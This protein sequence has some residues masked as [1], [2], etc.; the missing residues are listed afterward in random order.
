M[1]HSLLKHGSKI[2]PSFDDTDESC[3]NPIRI[4][5]P[6]CGKTID[7][8]FLANHKSISEIVGID[9]IRKAL[10]DF[11]ADHED[12]KMTNVENQGDGYERIRGNSIRLLKGDFFGLDDIKTGGRFDAV[13]DRASIVAID[14][15]L[16]E[17]YVATLRRLI[18]PGGSLLVSTLERRAGTEEGKNAGPPFSVPESEIRRLYEKQDWVESVSLLEEI[19]EFEVYPD[20]KPRYVS[21]GVTSFF[22]L[23]FEI[24]T[25]A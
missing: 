1:H 22:E 20:Q 4:F 19:D 2:I 7:M 15:S 10:D 24:K 8:A 25:K 21:Q 18:K 23:V 5:V 17:S 14:P 11:S 16:R 6:L 12:L 13:W 3:P 9:G